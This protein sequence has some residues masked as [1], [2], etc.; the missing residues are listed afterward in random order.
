LYAKFSKCEFWIKEVPFL[1]HMVSPDGIVVDPSR[2]KEVLEWKP[3]TTVSEVQ[4]FLGLAGYYRQFIPNFSKIVK[5]ITELLRNG[6]KYLWSEACD[7]AF[8]HL[9]RLLTTSSVL[10]QPDT[11][12]LFD[13]YCDASGTGLGGLLI[14]EGFCCDSGRGW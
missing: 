7:E 6:N 1:G 13:V 11:T 3:P 8:K 9:K 12:K 4:S 14:Q 2:V 5:P 10:A